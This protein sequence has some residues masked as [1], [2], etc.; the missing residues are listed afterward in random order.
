MDFGICSW[1]DFLERL[2]VAPP[3]LW[4][5]GGTGESLGLDHFQSGT[6]YHNSK[7]SWSKVVFLSGQV[8]L[9]WQPS[10]VSVLGRAICASAWLLI[11][12]HV[13]QS[14]RCW[15][16]GLVLWFGGGRSTKIWED[17][18]LQN[19]EVG[20]AVCTVPPNSHVKMWKP[21]SSCFSGSCVTCLASV[22]WSRLLMPACSGSTCR[23]SYQT[24]CFQEVLFKG[25]RHTKCQLTKCW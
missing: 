2:T 23:K 1:R 4:D 3:L 14:S 25:I 5:A 16:W 19:S 22:P 13:L 12:M 24:T 20:F 18:A 10:G 7:L 8:Q 17:K 6:E 9:L 11:L 15:W 21:A